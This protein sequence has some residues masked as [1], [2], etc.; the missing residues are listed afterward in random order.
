MNKSQTTEEGVS[1]LQEIFPAGEDFARCRGSLLKLAGHFEEPF[2]LTGSIAAGYHLLKKGAGKRQQSRFNDIDIVVKD[3]S[4][5]RASLR[6]DFL[7]SHFHPLRERG[8]ILIMLVDEENRTR[9]DVFTPRTISLTERLTEFAIGETSLRLVSAEDLLAKLLSILYP[10]TEGRPVEPKYL[11]HYRSLYAV[12]DLKTA[13]KIWHEYRNE[14][15]PV[16]FEEAAQAVQRKVA[17]N[18]ALL[19]A[20]SYS[21]DIDGVCSWCQ[22]SELFPIAPPPRIYKILG[23]V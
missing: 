12:A 8:K 18:P 2:A 6:R 5:L 16:D 22:T 19:Q 10:V 14:N 7:I 4:S 11:E 13:R 3:L 1:L 21:Q 17:L 9:I 15:R 20:G 23:Y